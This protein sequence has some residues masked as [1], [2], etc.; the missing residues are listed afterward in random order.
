MWRYAQEPAQR[1]PYPLVS[2]AGACAGCTTIPLP[3]RTCT[4]R[5]TCQCPLQHCS[6]AWTGEGGD[7]NSAHPSPSQRCSTISVFGPRLARAAL[8]LSTARCCC[9]CCCC[10]A[11]RASYAGC[12]YLTLPP[13]LLLLL[14]PLPLLPLLPLLLLLLLPLLLLLLLPLLLLLLLLLVGVVAHTWGARG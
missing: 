12:W 2:G 8:R 13:L 14:L 1:G 3:S 5:R 6:C 4:L 11:F 9:C 10:R 7:I